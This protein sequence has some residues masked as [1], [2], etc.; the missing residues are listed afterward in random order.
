MI[1]RTMPLVVI[2]AGALFCPSLARSQPGPADEQT[3]FPEVLEPEREAVPADANLFPPINIF[4]R[5]EDRSPLNYRFRWSPGQ[6]V[7]GQPTDLGFVQHNLGSRVPVW[8]SGP[9]L[10]LL[11]AEAQ[12]DSFQSDALLPDQGR[13][14]PENLWNLRVGSHYLHRF[15]NGWLGGTQVQVGSASD[16]PF[17]AFRDV[18]AS[19]IAFLRVPHHN[20][21]AWNFAL[22]YLPLSE[23]PYPLPMV[24]YTWQPS[25]TLR[26]NLGLPFQVTYR[27]CD[28]FTLAF[29]Y[30][31]LRTVR[32]RASYA[33]TE[34]WQ[35]YAAYDW[36][37]QSW[38]LHDRSNDRERLF[39][40]EQ[41]LT[42]GVQ[43][44]VGPV[45]LDL[46]AGYAFERFTFTGQRFADNDQNRIDIAPG[47]FV[48][49]QA[50]LTW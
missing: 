38:F 8:I 18:N 40:Y 27:P 36:T 41:R 24:A 3:L 46:S 10:V 11:S 26:V 16:Q 4:G 12:V 19:V 2:L 39:S 34:H 14:F 22:I 37:N 49:L 43:R 9:D 6:P 33:L 7:S 29:S 23:I 47:A 1:W 45:S 15:D 17:A 13:P 25:E 48:S 5:G 44:I 28:D 35:V 50:G 42:V 31:L 32:T 20:R 21:D 30:M